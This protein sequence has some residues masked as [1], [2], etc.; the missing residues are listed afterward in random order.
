[1]SDF[2]RA[3]PGVVKFFKGDPEFYGFIAPDDKT[4]DV[5]F[6]LLRGCTPYFGG[7]DQ[8]ALGAGTPRHPR[9]GDRV[10]FVAVQSRRGLTTAFW[11]FD[12][13]YAEIYAAIAARPTYRIVR[14]TGTRPRTRLAS[15]DDFQYEILWEGKNVH[16]LRGVWPAR[17]YPCFVR[18][19]IACYFERQEPD[20]TWTKVDKDPRL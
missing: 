4:K 2:E 20:G 17:L 3:V 12:D 16:D 13:T 7:G 8:P 1:M 9:K 18:D 5:H 10:R 19:G 6:H 14:R 11:F 15:P